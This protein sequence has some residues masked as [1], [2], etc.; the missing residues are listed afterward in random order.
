MDMCNRRGQKTNG[1]L[2]NRKICPKMK[3]L[4]RIGPK[5]TYVDGKNSM[6]PRC[7]RDISKVTLSEL[8]DGRF[9]TI[10]TTPQLILNRNG[11]RNTHRTDVISYKL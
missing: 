7:F 9:G 4:L 6:Q 10:T 2:V 1:I 3:E 11:N 5:K 8:F